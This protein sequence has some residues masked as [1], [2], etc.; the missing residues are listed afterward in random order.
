MTTR[1]QHRPDAALD[2]TRFLPLPFSSVKVPSLPPPESLSV[3][4]DQ[5]APQ[6][7]RPIALGNCPGQGSSP[8]SSPTQSKEFNFE[9][10][11]GERWRGG[12]WEQAC[13]RCQAYGSMHNIHQASEPTKL[14][15]A[16]NSSFPRPWFLLK[17]WCEQEPASRGRGSLGHFPWQD[18]RQR[19]LVKSKRGRHSWRYFVFSKCFDL[20]L[21]HYS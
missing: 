17:I 13:V 1:G 6:T 10:G 18:H 16:P 8:S 21:I 14:R 5:E 20:A 2:F 19:M 12:P 9:P 11:D 15:L 7:P 4:K 3:L